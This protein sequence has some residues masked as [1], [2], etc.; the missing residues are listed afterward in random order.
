MNDLELLCMGCMKKKPNKGTCPYCHF[1]LEHYE[2]PLHHLQPRTI[3]NGKYMVGRALGE[4]GFGITYIGWN[5]N[6]EIPL[7]IK[8][9]FPSGFVTRD[10]GRTDNVSVLSGNKAQFYEKGRE[11][12]FDEARI[13][14]KF[15]DMEG[16]VS[17]KDVFKEN[18]TAY[19]VMEYLDGEDFGSFLRRNGGKLPVE[20][21][22]EMMRP[23]MKA[24]IAVH[25][26]GLIHRDISPDNIRITT[27][28]NVKLI[29]FGAAREVSGGEKSLSIM[30]KP[31]YAPEE[32]YRTRGHQGPWTDVYALC[33]TMYRA[34]TGKKP[35]ESLDRM[36]RDELLSPSQLGV[37]IS[38]SQEYAI[39]KGMAVL[40]QN[41][42]QS[43]QELYDAIFS[44]NNQYQGE[45]YRVNQNYVSNRMNSNVDSTIYEPTPEPRHYGNQYNGGGNYQ[46]TSKGGE[47]SAQPIIIGLLIALIALVGIGGVM[48][49]KIAMGTDDSAN[50][51]SQVEETTKEE[52]TTTEA[53]TAAPT[54]AAPTTQAPTVVAPA[55]SAPV[56]AAKA[57]VITS[58]EYIIPGSDSRYIG[59]SDIAG[60]SS[61]EIKLA[62]N[63][64][65]ARHGRR[66][67]NSDIQAYFNRQSWYYGTIAPS[68][69]SYIENR[70]NDYERENV[71]FLKR[72]E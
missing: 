72:Y 43:I 20:S 52:V 64:I 63:E 65:Y 46:Q 67:N 66:F 32:Q 30:L 24:L 71:K 60:L 25:S 33:A 69:D 36:G 45:N 51:K 57:P 12:F 47:S 17:V 62:K 29:D 56:T 10:V 31:G 28:S 14:A 11:K 22:F 35:I 16:I 37:S 41:R 2:A 44:V 42:W 21:V 6:L 8:E 15:D 50:N 39:M 27:N 59:Y 23:V 68:N 53:T 48:M 4:G 61:W 26:K 19:I 38:Q 49:M 70:F 40:A 9:Y 7:A 3:L 13:L 1:D 5:L 58:S 55:T 54:T 34:I 18:G